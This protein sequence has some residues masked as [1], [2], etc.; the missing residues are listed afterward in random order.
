MVEATI[1]ELTTAMMDTMVEATMMETTILETTTTN[2]MMDTTEETNVTIE[3]A[4]MNVAV[5]T[6]SAIC[7]VEDF[8]SFFWTLACTEKFNVSDSAMLLDSLSK[9]SNET[10]DT[11]VN[12]AVACSS[13]TQGG[14]SEL[15]PLCYSCVCTVV[16]GNIW[17]SPSAVNS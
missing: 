1:A 2:V 9:G 8:T 12:R 7:D 14:G 5:T 10:I 4:E 16:F 6:A 13:S 15:R 17:C 3:L 11:E